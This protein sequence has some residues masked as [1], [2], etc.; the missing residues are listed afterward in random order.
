MD[1]FRGEKNLLARVGI[2]G[3]ILKLILNVLFISLLVLAMLTARCNTN[4]LSFTQ[5][6]K[7]VSVIWK[8]RCFGRITYRLSSGHP[9]HERQEWWK[10]P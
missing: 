3:R 10:S 7:T 5:T 9:S 2:T 1:G 4:T 8:S 6:F